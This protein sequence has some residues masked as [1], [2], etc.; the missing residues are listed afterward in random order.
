MSSCLVHVQCIHVCTHTLYLVHIH[1]H[2]HVDS[3]KETRQC[4]ATCIIP[5]GSFFHMEKMCCLRWDWTLQYTAYPVP[6]VGLDPAIYCIPCTVCGTGPCNI[7]HTLYRVWDWTLQY[8]AYPVPCVGLDPAIYCI[9]CTVCGTG[10]CNILHTLYR[11]W[12]WTLQYTAYPVPCVGLDPAIY[13]IPCTVC[14]TGPCNIL[15]T[16]YRVW[17]WTLQYTAYPVP[18]VGLDPA[19]YCI[20]C[21]VYTVL[22]GYMYIYTCTVA[23]KR[24]TKVQFGTIAMWSRYG[25]SSVT[26]H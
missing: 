4:K 23:K 16:L 22:S 2:V 1:V 10:P 6:C 20:P 15:H 12:D 7:L 24:L 11:V 5:K 14:G 8:T 18:C 17:D 25:C 9:P 13:C 3:V 26:V 21:T 19:I